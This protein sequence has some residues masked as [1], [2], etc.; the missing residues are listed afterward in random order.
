MPLEDSPRPKQIW[1][2]GRD[3]QGKKILNYEEGGSNGLLG[4]ESR[5]VL[6]LVLASSKGPDDPAEAWCV[7]VEGG[8]KPLCISTN[9]CG[10]A[11]FNYGVLRAG[12]FIPFI[13][14]ICPNDGYSNEAILRVNRIC[15]DKESETMSLQD[16]VVVEETIMY[17]RADEITVPTMAMGN[18]PAALCLT[19]ERFIIAIFRSM[20]YLLI[21]SFIDDKLTLVDKYKFG[22]YVVDA[23]IRRVS[24]TDGV[25]IVLLICEGEDMPDGRIVTVNFK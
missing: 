14:T 8:L 7:S 5:S 13:V 22:R 16:T 19:C 11:L 12:P 4:S 9:V 2:R 10:A 1:R 25:E 18:A 21:Y 17:D 6:A 15:I 24:T 20:G 3:L 23:A